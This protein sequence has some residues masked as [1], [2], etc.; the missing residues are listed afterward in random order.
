[1]NKHS[2]GDRS[3]PHICFFLSTVSNSMYLFF[4]VFPEDKDGVNFPDDESVAVSV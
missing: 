2:S 3:G 4:L 1:M